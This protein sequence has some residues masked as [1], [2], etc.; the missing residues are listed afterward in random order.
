MQIDVYCAKTGMHLHNI[1]FAARVAS[2]A[3][4]PHMEHVIAVGLE[5]AVEVWSLKGDPRRLFSAVQQRDSVMEGAPPPAEFAPG[6]AEEPALY[7]PKR[8]LVGIASDG[9]S[10]VVSRISTTDLENILSI[11]HYHSDYVPPRF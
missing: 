8:Y 4:H 9:S 11:L 3:L 7:T 5:N 10:L 6:E 2:M 1:H